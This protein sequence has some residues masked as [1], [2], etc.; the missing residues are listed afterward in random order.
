MDTNE[1]I[2]KY[3]QQPM[4]RAL[5]QLIPN[6]GGSIDTI[7]Y[8]KSAKWR[9]ERLN[10]FI[11]NIHQQIERDHDRLK[12]V[13]N[14]THNIVNEE[15]FY[16]LFLVAVS[17]SL[18]T[19]SKEKIKRFSNIISNYIIDD[20]LLEKAKAELMLN[21]LDDLS[22]FEILI[23]SRLQ[24]SEFS[25]HLIQNDLFVRARE[26]IDHLK[27]N[28]IEYQGLPNIPDNTK[29]SPEEF[30]FI[31]RLQSMQLIQ[32]VENNF[33]DSIDYVFGNQVQST[34]CSVSFHKS[35]DL[36]M[37]DFGTEFFK[38]VSDCK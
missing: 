7:L 38:W 16:D 26:L 17:S 32:K 15:D 21:I 5:V 10:E 31:N 6:I 4:L 24:E 11:K 29:V 30:F 19:K 20:G 9:E 18:K 13:E 28:Q 34:H 1:A 35:L 27:T 2:R 3:S 37:T 8:E 22:D 14:N 33:R 25:Y 12:V 36:K 23:I